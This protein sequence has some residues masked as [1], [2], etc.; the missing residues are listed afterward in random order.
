MNPI[1]Q[2]EDNFIS[3]LG[4][5]ARSKVHIV[6]PHWKLVPPKVKE[7]IWAQILQTFDVPNNK[8]M[9]KH[10]MGE[11]ERKMMEEELK[12]M[13]EASQVDPSIVVQPPARPP[14]HQKWKA[15]RMKGDKYINADVA[16]VASKIDALEQQSSQGSFTPATQ[17]N[18]LSTAIGKPD[19]LDAVRGETRKVIL[20]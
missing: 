9:N 1:G 19:Y 5:L 7:L 20:E 12:R 17:M 14:H 8:A 16:E 4:Y 18:I 13:K 11:L 15:A 6:Y 10:W 3:Y 2:E